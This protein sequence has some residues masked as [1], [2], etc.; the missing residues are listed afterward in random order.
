MVGKD[1]DM[2]LVET[3]QPCVILDESIEGWLSEVESS[4]DTHISPEDDMY[5]DSAKHYF[6]VGRAALGLIVKLGF[7]AGRRTFRRILD[8]PSG[9]GRVLRF[10]RAA[11]PAA[12]ITACDL[13]PDAV[14]FC[15]EHYNAHPHISNE[16]A[17]EIRIDDS[18]DI[19][20]CGSLFTHIEFD[21]WHGF[22]QLFNS[23]L[24]KDGLLIFTTAGRHVAHL[25]RER[26]THNWKGAED[27]YGE[28][29]NFETTGVAFRSFP[30]NFLN[31][32]ARDRYNITDM[33][34]SYGACYASSRRVLGELERIAGLS[35]LACIE[36][37]WDGRQDVYACKRC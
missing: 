18:F 26:K 22:L 4:V 29:V 6:S 33:E 25:A 13:E 5:L 36:R 17:G 32:W 14:Q 27:S 8:F 3:S 34:Y 9:H 16:S 12:H 1:E 30:S 15:A 20:W 31:N 10:L 35:P 23:L 28:L 37:G 11:F 7:L 21:R 24:E 2:N 19:I